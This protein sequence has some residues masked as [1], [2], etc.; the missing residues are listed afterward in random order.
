M[1]LPSPEEVQGMLI[2]SA[3]GSDAFTVSKGEKTTWMLEMEAEKAVAAAQA[4][5]Q[6]GQPASVIPNTP[7]NPDPAPIPI[8]G[9]LAGVLKYF[10]RGD[11]VLE[12]AT[13]I[14]FKD[15]YAG[16]LTKGVLVLEP[17]CDAEWDAAKPMDVPYANLKRAGLHRGGI[18]LGIDTLGQWIKS[19]TYGDCMPNGSLADDY[20]CLLTLLKLDPELTGGKLEW[21]MM[22]C[23]ITADRVRVDFGLI[24]SNI[25]IA[26]G[27]TYS[28]P[29]TGRRGNRR[30][31]PSES[32]VMQAVEA[33]AKENPY[34]PS[35]E[36]LQLG[37]TWDGTDYMLLLLK[38]IGGIKDTAGL[39]G[40][41]LDWVMKTNALAL[42]QLT[43]TLVGAV[44]RTMDPGCQMDTM[45]VLKSKQGTKKSSLFRAIAPARRF[46][47]AHFDFGSK[48]SRITFMQNTL[49]EVAEL[50]S[51]QRKDIGL[52]K[53]EITERSDDFRQPYARSMTKNPRWCIMVG[54]TNDDTFLKDQTGSRRFWVIVVLDDHKTDIPYVE[55]IIPQVWAQALFLYLG[56]AACPTCAAA[57]DGEVRC[58][59]HRWWLSLEEDE[60]REK[61]NEQFT[62][63]EPYVDMVKDWLRN[64][65]SDKKTAKQGLHTAHKN[66]DA[67]K[68]HEVL[69]AVA[70]LPPEKCGDPGHQRRMAYALKQNG[71]V[72]KHTEDG[73]VWISP[74]M[75]NRPDLSIVRPV[76]PP[77]PVKK[78][79]TTPEEL[80]ALK[81]AKT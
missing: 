74:G 16:V 9:K 53:A 41:A 48:D 81:K 54:S 31:V 10:T 79:E 59:D 67:L 7:P 13:K 26:I 35:K 51:M 34:H 45:L 24:I 46:S 72:K 5:Q 69:E 19:K 33:I 43:K 37:P 65:L 80:E 18:P 11:P 15:F 42:S 62:E 39:A 50:S 61:Y 17:A 63:Q 78:E 27:S 49:I 64:T 32:F 75:Q 60:L 6:A 70:N 66:T 57:A 36:Y 58:P 22:D 73:N 47:S 29:S 8:L 20:L 71:Y 38:A 1:P 68:I 76:D 30:F 2:D 56:A 21:N 52:V 12:A 14:R 44:A 4:R 25:R 40:E 3:F 55:S 23:T 77:K 28:V